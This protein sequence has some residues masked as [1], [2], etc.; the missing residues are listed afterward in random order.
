MPRSTLTSKG[1]V[2]IPKAIRDRLEL[3]EGDTLDFSL[4]EAGRIVVRLERTMG[5]ICGVLSEFA[6]EK[7]VSVEAMKE[8]VRR[9]FARTPSSGR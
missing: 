3:H 4:D 7:P 1:Q 5:G 2:T 6:P 8:A 9:R